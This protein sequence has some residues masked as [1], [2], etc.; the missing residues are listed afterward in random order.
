[1]K[2]QLNVKKEI[3]THG[4][5]MIAIYVFITAG[6]IIVSGKQPE[7]VTRELAEK[8]T[9]YSTKAEEGKSDLTSGSSAIFSDRMMNNLYEALIPIAE[10]ALDLTGISTINFPEGNKDEMAAEFTGNEDII[11]MLAHKN[12]EVAKECAVYWSM[13]DCLKKESEQPL[14]IE[15]WMVSDDFWDFE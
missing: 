3:Q 4:I 7:V 2:T 14:K 15:N 5:L 1:M 9:S 13:K 6:I 10:P 12:N 8:N 11:S